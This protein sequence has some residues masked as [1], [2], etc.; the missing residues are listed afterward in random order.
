MNVCGVT[1]QCTW[2]NSM[3]NNISRQ[4]GCC[5]LNTVEYNFCWITWHRKFSF[6][7]S[8]YLNNMPLFKTKKMLASATVFYPV[9]I[10]VIFHSM[11]QIQA[12]LFCRE[13]NFWPI[14]KKVLCM[15]ASTWKQ[16]IVTF[17]KS[18]QLLNFSVA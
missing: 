3:N 10:F 1:V 18:W 11:K 5:A 4:A 16:H 2:V 7:Q 6:F 12:K 9:G 15:Y 17:S 14:K 13:N 8:F